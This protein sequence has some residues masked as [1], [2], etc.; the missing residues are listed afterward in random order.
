[1]GQTARRGLVI[2]NMG[3]GKG[4]TTAALGV[5]MRAWGR[6]M[7]VAMYQFIKSRRL[8]SGEH[9][10]AERMGLLLLPLGRG[11]TRSSPNPEEDERLAREC[12][13]RA[14]EAMG[15]GEYDIVI[16][17]ELTYPLS[18]GWIDLQEVLK[19]L[20][21][22]PPG[23]HVIITG[24]QAPEELVEFADLVTEMREVKHPFRRGIK[25]QPGIEF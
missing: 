12:W 14:K 1:M 15:S 4:K 21:G 17:D 7:K 25:G 24:R 22:R 16:L 20:A 8:R 5:M 13:A 3:A 18:Y 9:R 23:Q 6:G 19:T 10:A 11:F 2:L